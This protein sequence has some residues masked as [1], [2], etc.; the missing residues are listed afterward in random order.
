MLTKDDLINHLR[1]RSPVVGLVTAVDD[2]RDMM[3]E[4]EKACG[5][6]YG[7]GGY[8]LRSTLTPE[9]VAALP[10]PPKKKTRRSRA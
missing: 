5:I 8:A 2:L 1:A 4:A 6:D 7:G 9:P 3:R 10:R